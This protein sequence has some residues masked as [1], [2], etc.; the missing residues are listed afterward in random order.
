M[1][2]IMAYNEDLSFNGFYVKG[3]HTDIPVPNI[4][5][6]ND[7]WNH[8]VSLNSFKLKEDFIEKD[9][10]T[11][12]DKDLFEEFTPYPDDLPAISTEPTLDNRVSDLE[13]ENADLLL[14]SVE[15]GLKLEVIEQDLA[16]LMLEISVM[17]EV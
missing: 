9:E 12:D 4:T 7:L 14:A 16:D 15:Q 2:Y 1:K 11:I 13:Q 3:I 10:Y 8:L 5:I 6:S 17:R